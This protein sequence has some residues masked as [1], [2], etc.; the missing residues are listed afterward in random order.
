MVRLAAKNWAT[1]G[2]ILGSNDIMKLMLERDLMVLG[3]SDGV[4]CAATVVGYVLQRLILN[5]YL[6]WNTE[7]WI[8]Q[9]VGS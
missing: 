9:N 7:G 8:I 1:H 2:N 4:L 3:L 6:K 5:N